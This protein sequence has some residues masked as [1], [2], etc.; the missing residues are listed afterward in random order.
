[1]CASPLSPRQAQ[2][3]WMGGG[4]VSRQMMHAPPS[5]A[6]YTAFPGESPWRWTAQ[7]DEG[8]AIE[9]VC[10]FGYVCLTTCEILGIH[11][12]Q[13]R[14]RSLTRRPPRAPCRTSGADSRAPVGTARMVCCRSPSIS[15]MAAAPIRVQAWGRAAWRVRKASPVPETLPFLNFG[16]RPYKSFSFDYVVSL[17]QSKSPAEDADHVAFSDDSLLGRCRR[18]HEEACLV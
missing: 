11:P 18:Y 1:M 17:V 14:R 16:S 3:D 6:I 8:E 4:L 5:A 2:P 12:E 15:G 13:V 7:A 10:N 9:T